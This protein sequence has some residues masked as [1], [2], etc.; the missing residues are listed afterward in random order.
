MRVALD[1]NLLVLLTIGRVAP[2]KL[3]VH[4]RVREYTID[5]YDLLSDCISDRK[6]VTSPNALTETSNLTRQGFDGILKT[7]V[8]M[9]FRDLISKADEILIASLPSSQMTEFIWLGLA[10]TVWLDLPPDTELLTADAVLYTAALNRGLNA[11]NF[12]HLREAN[13]TI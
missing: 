8:I 11:T 1:T 10:D 2:D 13:R 4:K 6:I 3:G 5:D 9:A 7:N 12:N